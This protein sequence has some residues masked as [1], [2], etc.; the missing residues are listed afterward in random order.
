[1]A[2]MARPPEQVEIEADGR[3]EPPDSHCLTVVAAVQLCLVPEVPERM[4]HPDFRT[5]D[6]EWFSIPNEL[7]RMLVEEGARPATHAS[8]AGIAAFVPGSPESRAT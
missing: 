7:V 8:Y 6:G 3:G 4:A 1:M 2:T 5:P